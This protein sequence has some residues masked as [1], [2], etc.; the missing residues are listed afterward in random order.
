MGGKDYGMGR[1]GR[2]SRKVEWGKRG[3]PWLLRG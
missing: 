2:E 1:R 3:A